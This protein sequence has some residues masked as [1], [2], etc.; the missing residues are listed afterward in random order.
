MKLIPP[1]EALQKARNYCAFQ[2]R[3]Q[4]EVREKLLQWKQDKNVV[5][6]HIAQLI[7]EG[8]IDEERFARA[9]AGGKFRMKQWGRKK[10]EIELKQRALSPY[11][12][13]SGLSEIA[14]GDYLNTLQRLAEK[15]LKR[16]KAPNA[17]V[18]A[19]KVRKYLLSRGFE[20]DLV[21]DI[22]RQLI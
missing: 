22:L 21:S 16:T 8:Y 19:L 11:C 18:R 15:A 5:E 20:N 1:G 13:R 12:V 4:Q 2:E 14:Q 6:S 10:I 17:R 9:F 3:C 7:S